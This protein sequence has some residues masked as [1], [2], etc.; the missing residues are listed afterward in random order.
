MRQR[1]AKEDM[2]KR[3]KAF[4]SKTENVFLVLLIVMGLLYMIALPPFRMIDEYRHFMR[5]YEVADGHFLSASCGPKGLDQ[6]FLKTAT[7]EKW[8]EARH[9]NISAEM[10]YMSDFITGYS[11]FTY[12]FAVFP[13]M[14]AKLFTANALILIYCARMGQ[15]LGC[16]FLLYLAVKYIPVGKN[17]VM[18]ISLL[19]MTLQEMTSLSGD[20]LAI[21]LSIDVVAFVLYQMANPGKKMTFR[22]IFAMYSMA[23]LLGQ[24]KYIYVFFCLLFFFIPRENFGGIKKKVLHAVGAG[25]ITAVCMLLWLFATGIIEFPGTI[26]AEEVAGSVQSVNNTNLFITM[27]KTFRANY[28]LYIASS[29]AEC[30]GSFDICVNKIWSDLLILL[31]LYAGLLERKSDLTL[32]WK[33]R[34]AALSTS[35]LSVVALFYVFRSS[36][37]LVRETGILSGLQGRYFIPVFLPVFLA[38]SLNSKKVRFPIINKWL[39][40]SMVGG[41]DLCVG[42]S[43]LSI[44]A[45]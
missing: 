6:M 18:I 28:R 16:V 14:L 21:T 30:F 9:Y 22:E 5:A 24:C 44:C 42:I 34:L 35:V 15:F 25:G 41:I 23:F 17:L 45:K 27:L 38:A 43:V 4:C 19:P 2:G 1:K 37:W 13:L 20:A 7:I 36:G 3:T 12:V 29:V 26:K 11:P 8:F 10:E 31:L 40:L 33:F 39:F 32:S